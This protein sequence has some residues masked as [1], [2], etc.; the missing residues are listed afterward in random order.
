[1]GAYARFQETQWGQAGG[2]PA[3]R[4]FVEQEA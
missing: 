2:L 1:M 4:V 3:L